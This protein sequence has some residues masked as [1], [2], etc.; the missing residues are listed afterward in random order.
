MLHSSLRS[1]KLSVND[2]CHF[3]VLVWEALFPNEEHLPSAL[4]GG[5]LQAEDSPVFLKYRWDETNLWRHRHKI[6]ISCPY[7][8]ERGIYTSAPHNE[9]EIIAGEYHY[10]HLPGGNCREIR[11]HS[12][13]H[14]INTSSSEHIR[15]TKYWSDE[16]ISKHRTCRGPQK[17]FLPIKLI[18]LSQDITQVRLH[19]TQTN[20]NASRY[21][22]LS[23]YWGTSTD[24]PM[25]MSSTFTSF[26]RSI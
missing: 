4:Q 26:A 8:K 1:L 12:A 24:I 9:L 14:Y 7:L 2:L 20:D 23:H 15:L 17:G 18:V 19:I 16:C 10:P 3:C 11:A 25:L 13:Q 21:V 6:T 5:N 22:A